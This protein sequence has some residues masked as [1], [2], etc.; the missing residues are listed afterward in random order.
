M[1]VI[2]EPT[3]AERWLYLQMTS[4]P[5][6][7]GIVGARVFSGVAPVG[8]QFPFVIISLLA[9]G[10]DVYGN[11]PTIIWSRLTYLVKAVTQANSLTSLQTLVDRIQAVLH[12]TRGGTS[13]A[14]ID[15]C[16]R[17]RPFRMTQYENN[18]AFQHLGGEFEIAV[19]A[20]S[21]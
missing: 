16:V 2:S 8:T 17:K 7:A 9:P 3:R 19:R 1:T 5:T 6:I 12:A 13:D 10:D 20:S 11:G 15:Y 21:V 18:V 4:D 14:A